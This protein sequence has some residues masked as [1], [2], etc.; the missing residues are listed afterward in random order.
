[1]A[2]EK[3][4]S[5]S[6]PVKTSDTKPEDKST[7][8]GTYNREAYFAA[9]NKIIRRDMN[10]TSHRYWDDDGMYYFPYKRKDVMKYMRDPAHHEK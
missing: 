2:R 1:M 5:S 4:I 3:G 7:T 9:L 8:D 10:N 6:K